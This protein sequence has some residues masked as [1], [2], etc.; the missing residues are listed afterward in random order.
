MT[1]ASNARWGSSI[2]SCVSERLGLVRRARRHDLL[3]ALGAVATTL[4]AIRVL[5]ASWRGGFAPA[6]P[7]SASYLKVAKLGPFRLS[8]WFGERPIVVPALYWMLGRNVRLIV[9]AQTTLALGVGWW[10]IVSTWRRCHSHIARW[11]AVALIAALAVQSRFVLWTTQILSESLS[12]TLG[13]AAVLAWL[14]FADRGGA[15]R[16]R[17]AFALTLLWALCRDSNLPIALFSTVP[18]ALLLERRMVGAPGTQRALLRGAAAMIAVLGYV[19]I[20]S[21]SS[22]RNIYP[23]LNVI[24]QRVLVDADLTDWY[25]SWGMPVDP[26]VM[27]RAGQSSFDDDFEVLRAP[28]LQH[29]RDWAEDR[30]QLVQAWSMVRLAPDFVGDVWDDLGAELHTDHRDYDTFQVSQR[31]PDRLPLGLGGPRSVRALLV[32]LAAAVV[33]IAFTAQRRR[34]LA[35]GLTVALLGSFVDLYTSWL[36]DSVEVQRH[37]V[38]A[39]FRLSLVLALAVVHGLDAIASHVGA[40][41][42]AS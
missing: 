11:G 23:T 31:L 27:A 22:D 24:G 13:T 30:G 6:F 21:S 12:M 20:A 25:A 40:R 7:D 33:G 41:R 29:L 3:I 26:T 39:V 8:F 18:I 37:L 38:G 10:A 4:V 17:A 9:L 5:G 19:A 14:A 28:E 2:V 34:G 32:W 35:L 15:R 36:G 1:V 42:R 16:C